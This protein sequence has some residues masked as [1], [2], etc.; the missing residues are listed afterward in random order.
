MLIDQELFHTI[1]IQS[2]EMGTA[3]TSVVFPNDVR[4]ISNDDK[5][6]YSEY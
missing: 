6:K 1:D 3:K 4:A 5:E 2:F